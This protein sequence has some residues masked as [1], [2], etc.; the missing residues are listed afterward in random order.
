[1]ADIGFYRFGPRKS[2]VMGGA[3]SKYF[4]IHLPKLPFLKERK[5]GGAVIMI[6][7]TRTLARYAQCLAPFVS[8]LKGS[9]SRN[10][11]STSAFTIVIRD[12]VS[13]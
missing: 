6:I 9:P 3:R 1:L 7:K 12:R 13:G 10:K 4:K 5:K 11:K 2:E 8:R